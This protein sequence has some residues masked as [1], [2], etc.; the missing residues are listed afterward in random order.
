MKIDVY[1]ITRTSCSIS[2]SWFGK[3]RFRELPRVGDFLNFPSGADVDKFVITEVIY[4]LKR[5]GRVETRII[6]EDVKE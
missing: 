4:T 3:Y 6:V 1:N 2:G 5:F